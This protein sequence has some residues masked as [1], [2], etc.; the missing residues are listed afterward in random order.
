[1]SGLPPLASEKCRK[2]EDEYNLQE[3]DNRQ[4]IALG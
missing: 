3:F 2:F 4:L 1:M